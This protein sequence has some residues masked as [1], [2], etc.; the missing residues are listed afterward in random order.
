MKKKTNE[1]HF[2]IDLKSYDAKR[3]EEVGPNRAAAEWLL[4][5]GAQIKFT[6]WGDYVKDYNRIPPGGIET[7]KIEEI[8]AENACIMARGFEYLRKF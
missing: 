4:R 1:L 2:H 7:Y 5:C 8:R 3:V 6:N